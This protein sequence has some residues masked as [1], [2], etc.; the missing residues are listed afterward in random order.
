[1][2]PVKQSTTLTVPF[3]AHDAN[4]D[5]VTGIGDGSYT[6]RISKNGGAFAAMTVTITEMENGWYSLPIGTGHSDTLGVL[7]ISISSGSCKR[8]NL[9]FRVHARLPDDLA[10]PATSGR[11]IGVETDGH[12]HA[13]LKEWLGT[14]PVNTQSG[15]VDVYIGALAP[16]VISATHLAANAIGSSEFSQA[17]ADKVWATA[18]RALTDKAGFSLAADQSAVTIGTV[19]TLTGHTAQTG[20]VYAAL[21][22]NF[23]D[24]S[25]SVTTGLVDITQTAADKAWSTAA[26]ALTDKAGFSLAAD[27]SAVTIGTVTTLTGH[28]AQTGD[29]YA[30]LPTN[31]SDLSISVTTGLVDITQTAADKAWATAAR[32]LTDKAG[33]SLAADQSAV[34]IGTVNALAADS[35]DASALATDAVSEIANAIIPEK[36]AAFSNIVFLMVNSTDH[37]TPETGLTVTATRSIDGGAFAAGT[38]TGPAEIGNGIYQYDASQADMNGDVVMFRFSASGA[39]DRFVFIKTSV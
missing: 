29:V 22:T 34:T 9:Q 3:F 12:V 14:A 21:P 32:A 6:K 39:D 25:I 33:F 35:V 31:F 7:S 5:G 11:S 19:T 1:M 20:D 38:G 27:Q 28:T 2:Y 13:D 37:V 36:N 30:A 15:R 10:Y 8:V 4:G 26:R 24:L 17:A 18:A 23:S 16:S